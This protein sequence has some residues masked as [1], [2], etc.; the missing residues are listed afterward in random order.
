MSFAV[1]MPDF[2][3][4]LRLQS[5]AAKKQDHRARVTI[6]CDHD[7][8]DGMTMFIW[9]ETFGTTGL[10]Y[11]AL[12]G[13]KG[14]VFSM[15]PLDA[16]MRRASSATTPATLAILNK[17]EL[18][19]GHFQGLLFGGSQVLP[20]DLFGSADGNSTTD[21][22]GDVAGTPPTSSK[23]STV[24][25]QEVDPVG[26]PFSTLS[27]AD[28]PQVDPWEFSGIYEFEA[29]DENC[30]RQKG[31][32]KLEG[33]DS[34]APGLLAKQ[35]RKAGPS[36]DPNQNCP[37]RKGWLIVDAK[38]GDP[39]IYNLD[40]GSFV[41]HHLIGPKWDGGARFQSV[42][43]NGDTTGPTAGMFK[44]EGEV[45]P[46]GTLNFYLLRP[47][48]GKIGRLAPEQGA[49]DKE[50]PKVWKTVAPIHA[51]KQLDAYCHLHIRDNDDC[52][53]WNNKDWTEYLSQARK[54]T[55]RSQGID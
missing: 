37:L 12:V 15:V 51:V 45:Q 47:N 7:V 38:A 36:K 54:E 16:S 23:D 41:S 35:R 11:S 33:S 8:D 53:S 18:R 30:L 52:A 4:W 13:D 6:S 27:V 9:H 46:D 14:L 40:H 24:D 10:A 20:Q 39:P 3:R 17:C 25:K 2:R 49:S 5:P 26:V 32:M 1:N 28:K 50:W 19:K 34:L 43:P 21:W 44:I 55:R 29:D 31:F 48:I 42:T 22:I